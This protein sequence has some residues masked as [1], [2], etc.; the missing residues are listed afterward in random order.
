M[1]EDAKQRRTEEWRTWLFLTFVMAPV[2]AVA[3]VGGYGFVVW[4]VQLFTGPPSY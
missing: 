3:V 4:M 1:T 2:L